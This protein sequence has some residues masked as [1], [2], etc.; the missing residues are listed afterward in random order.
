VVRL[1][2][3]WKVS[4]LGT[5]A[6]AAIASESIGPPGGWSV[7]INVFF[8]GWGSHAL[9]SSL[10]GGMRPPG[11]DASPFYDYFYHSG[12]L[13]FH[14]APKLFRNEDQTK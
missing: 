10:V 6:I 7:L 9:G 4:I 13:L 3:F 12:H 11:P 5:A 1:A 14:R 8:L 2:L